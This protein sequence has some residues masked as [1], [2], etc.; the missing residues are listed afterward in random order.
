MKKEKEEENIQFDR[1]KVGEENVV[2]S[3]CGGTGSI[4]VRSP[5]K[6]YMRG[7]KRQCPK[8]EGKGKTDWVTSIMKRGEK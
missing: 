7:Q 3:R 8:C 6:Y 5:N 1:M 2:C 4:R